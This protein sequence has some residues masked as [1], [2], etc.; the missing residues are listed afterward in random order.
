[1]LSWFVLFFSLVTLALDLLLGVEYLLVNLLMVLFARG[2]YV[3]AFT[4]RY[5]RSDASPADHLTKGDLQYFW[6]LNYLIVF[7]SVVLP[8]VGLFTAVY[9]CLMAAGY[10]KETAAL[11][12][13]ARRRHERLAA[14]FLG[15]AFVLPV[16]NWLVLGD[17]LGSPFPALAAF[18][19]YLAF[20]ARVVA[21]PPDQF[22]PRYGRKPLRRV[23]R[24]ARVVLVTVLV[25]LPPFL[26]TST[27]VAG[28]RRVDRDVDVAMRDG[29]HLKTDVYYAACGPGTPRP[30]V[31][32]RTP[33]GK[34]QGMF[35]L[36]AHIYASQG[37]H[38]VM[39]DIRGTGE[40]EG[41]LQRNIIMTKSYSDGAD[42]IAWI[43]AQPW[44]N[45]QVATNGVSAMC[46]DQYLLAG[47]NP[48]GLRAQ[49][50]WFGTPDMVQDAIL[51]GA[52]H[53][54][55]V[56]NWI[57]QV[58]G[59]DWRYQLDYIYDYMNDPAGIFDDPGPRAV[60]LATGENTYANVS[61]HGLHVGGWWDHFIGGTI[62]GYMGYDD[63]GLPS[64][65][66]HQIMVIGPWTHGNVFSTRQGGVTYPA[67]AMGFFD[68]VDLEVALFEE[69]FF[70][71]SHP[72]LWQDRVRY[73]V[74][75]DVDVNPP[76][77]N[78]WKSAPDWPLNFTPNPW[79]VGYEDATTTRGVL[80]DSAATLVPRNASYLYDPRDPVINLGG[81]NDPS[82]DNEVAPA[83]PF[84]QR[85]V[86]TGRSDILQ[87]ESAP[88][89]APYTIEGNLT[90]TV[91]LTSNASDTDVMVKL[92][93]VYPDGKRML[94]ADSALTCRVRDNLTS[95]SPP[96]NTA[97]EVAVDID[98]VAIAYQF[99]AGHQIAVSI[100]SSNWNRYALNDNTGGPYP[101]SY[102]GNS[103]VANNTI[104]TGPGK[105]CIYLPELN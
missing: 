79:Y 68:L 38:F 46:I 37:Y 55:L 42:T 66:G 78:V 105:T 17:L 45:G 1:M 49:S 57:Q 72:E 92:V 40:S 31:L 15:L 84:D 82:R 10:L 101:Q 60:T 67:N 14:A 65:R 93:D 85:P 83:G 69:A 96:L 56:R 8:L 50:L 63:H 11:V 75:G 95:I 2:A 16:V 30:V 28:F 3:Y 64:A 25:A 59:P 26:V 29:V 87:F 70:N 7:F 18:V 21:R 13:R 36:Y 53:E 33:Y 5:R 58:S 104:V 100:T 80:V 98:L 91:F 102:V 39:Q 24:P 44:C 35:S 71:V 89:P 22:V 48:T 103:V 73:Y 34:D 94:V 74:M 51:E 43:R 12:P 27:L 20:G 19:L 41:D 47:T 76:G 4:T 88:L 86:E 77:A 90:A 61:V 9:S 99:N 62:R 32:Q 23:Q 81:R 97:G 6:L 52:Y 54:Y